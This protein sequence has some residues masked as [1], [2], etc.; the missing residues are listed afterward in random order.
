DDPVSWELRD[1]LAAKLP[2][3]VARSLLRLPH[4]HPRAR[5]LRAQLVGRAPVDVVASLEGAG[6]EEAWGLRDRIYSTAADI[7]VASTM[8]LRD[9]R[10]W[11]TRNRWL[12]D[13]GG[14]AAL[15]S[16]DLARVACRAVTGVDD[17]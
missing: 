13:R 4:K 5:R 17:D 16:Y 2:G 15:T 9:G 3:R 12:T 10:A 1:G 7:V 14:P 6:D 11:A 8:H